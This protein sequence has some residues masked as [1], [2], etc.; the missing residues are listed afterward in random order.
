MSSRFGSQIV[1]PLIFFFFFFLNLW[2][3][4]TLSK[5]RLNLSS[6]CLCLFVCLSVQVQYKP[7]SP[8][9]SVN[10][11]RYNVG[12]SA[13]IVALPWRWGQRQSNIAAEWSHERGGAALQLPSMDSIRSVAVWGVCVKLYIS[14]VK[15]GWGRGGWGGGSGRRSHSLLYPER[16]LDGET[17]HGRQS[18][19]GRLNAEQWQERSRVVHSDPAA[20]IK[21]GGVR[22]LHSS[23][24]KSHQ[25]EPCLFSSRLVTSS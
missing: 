8:D 12:V 24:C 9:N 3:Q 22:C 2:F 20:T 7:P 19:R 11:R 23:L 4:Q 25:P 14:L 18:K 21:I 17:G 1:I 15:R 6:M 13:L 10:V 5:G 16:P